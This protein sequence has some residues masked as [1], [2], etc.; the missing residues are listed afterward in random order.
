MLSPL[1]RVLDPLGASAQLLKPTAFFDSFL[2]QILF[3][4]KSCFGKTPQ[5]TITN[6]I[7]EV[8]KIQ[9]TVVSPGSS[10]HCSL[11]TPDST[12]SE[13]AHGPV[14]FTPAKLEA[15]GGDSMQAGTRQFTGKPR[16]TIEE[17]E[18]VSF[19]SS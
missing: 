1:M 2:F 11:Y 15:V 13:L 7:V 3:F 8:G 5:H 17:L 16:Y 10:S 6:M 9:E 12:M 19:L 14:L 4:I 18:E